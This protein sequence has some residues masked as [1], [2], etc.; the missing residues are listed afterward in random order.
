MTIR[1]FVGVLAF[2]ALTVSAAWAGTT[3]YQVGDY[4]YCNDY[5]TGQTTTCYRVG[6]YTYCN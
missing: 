3:C 6:D 4:T 5:S 2:L 1:T